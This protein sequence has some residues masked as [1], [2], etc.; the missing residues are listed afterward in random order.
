MAKTQEFRQMQDMLV[1]TDNNLRTRKAEDLQGWLQTLNDKGLALAL[2]VA[3]DLDDHRQLQT[4][5]MLV[6][7]ERLRQRATS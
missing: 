3:A 1:T 6:A 7:A 4:V 5:V 2:V